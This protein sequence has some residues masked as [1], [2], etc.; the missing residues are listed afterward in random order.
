MRGGGVQI[1]V[2]QS[3]RDCVSLI[4]S[5]YFRVYAHKA[6]FIRIFLAGFR[7][8]CVKYLL[9]MRLASYRKGILY[10]ICKMMNDHYSKKYGLYIPPGT[11]IGWGF[12]IGHGI[13]IVVNHTAVIGNN[14]DLSQCSTIGSNEGHAAWIGNN[15]YIGPNVSVVEDVHIGSNSIIGAGSVVTRS[16]VGNCTAVGVPCKAIG[17]NNHP[18][19]VNNRWPL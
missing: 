15:V 17:D 6:S 11:K 12:Y 7:N 10:P 3:Y 5:D 2:P 18:E 13:A 19:Y 14:V 16:I 1:P 8:H 4:Q 9:W